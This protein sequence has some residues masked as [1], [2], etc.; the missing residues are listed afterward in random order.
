M[1]WILNADFHE[2][3]IPPT[4]ASISTVPSSPNRIAVSGYEK[5]MV[6]DLLPNQGMGVGRSARPEATR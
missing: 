6:K 1:T 5:A 3:L 4:L 2:A